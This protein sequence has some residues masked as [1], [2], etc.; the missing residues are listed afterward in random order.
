MAGI[1]GIIIFQHNALHSSSVV[2][3]WRDWYFGPMAVFISRFDPIENCWDVL[4]GKVARR[5]PSSTSD[6]T[7]QI[8]KFW[9]QE[10]TPEYCRILVLSMLSQIQAVLAEFILYYMP[11]KSIVLYMFICANRM[12]LKFFLFCVKMLHTS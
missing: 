3:K 6:L 4:K 10:I 11:N 2:S 9:T 5:K 12:F 1:T 8:L 7:Q